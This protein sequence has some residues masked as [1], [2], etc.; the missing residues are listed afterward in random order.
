VF[1]PAYRRLTVESGA[2]VTTGTFSNL[3]HALSDAQRLMEGKML[4]EIQPD[5]HE[6]GRLLNQLGR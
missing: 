2:V 1:L 4:Y 6:V 3:P 5:T